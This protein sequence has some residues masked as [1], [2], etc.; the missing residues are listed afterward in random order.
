MAGTVNETVKASEGASGVSAPGFASSKVFEDIEK[1]MKGMSDDAKK[2]QVAKVNAVF[3]FDVKSGDQVV[4]WFVDL[5]NGSGAVGVG[6]PPKA[7]MTVAVADQDLVALAGGKLNP[8]KAFMQGK[9]KVKGNMG[10]AT[11]LDTVLKAN[12]SKM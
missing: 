11:K 12:K 5:K 1:M 7:D 4:S 3:A 8:Q 2:A 9:I 10:L 6:K